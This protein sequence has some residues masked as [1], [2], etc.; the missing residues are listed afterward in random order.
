MINCVHFSIVDSITFIPE[1]FL[2][3][4]END[5]DGSITMIFVN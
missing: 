3:A 5:G 4:L 1:I 2:Q